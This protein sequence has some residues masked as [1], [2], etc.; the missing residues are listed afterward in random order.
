MY[1]YVCER[2]GVLC[3][4]E[5]MY[6]VYVCCVCVCYLPLGLLRL[7]LPSLVM[8]N[9]DWTSVTE[10]ITLDLLRENGGCGWV[11]GWVG[12]YVCVC[13]FETV[14]EYV[15]VFA[16]ICMIVAQKMKGTAN[17]V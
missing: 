17:D 6:N 8:L 15:C 2:V 9:L 7:C 4:C 5:Y 16:C 11:G 1:M 12:L 3:V 14:T 13:E 10:N